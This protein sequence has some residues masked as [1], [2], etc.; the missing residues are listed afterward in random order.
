MRTVQMQCSSVDQPFDL[1]IHSNVYE[2][3]EVPVG[4]LQAKS[5]GVCEVGGDLKM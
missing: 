2:A 3:V 5:I 4:M 1:Q